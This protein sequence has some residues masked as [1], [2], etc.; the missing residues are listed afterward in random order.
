M[1][2]LTEEE[3]AWLTQR[4]ALTHD[5][6]GL[7]IFLGL[8]HEESE[9]YQLLSD[10]RTSITLREAMEFLILDTKHT[11]AICQASTLRRKRIP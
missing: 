7:E 1:L 11:R 10:P 6:Q 4:L 8:T 2:D 3:R 9:R 5:D